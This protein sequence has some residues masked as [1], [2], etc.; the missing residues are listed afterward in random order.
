MIP[1]DKN[2]RHSEGNLFKKRI[3]REVFQD[4]LSQKKTPYN[5][6]WSTLSNCKYMFVQI[7]ITEERLG[8]QSLNA[9]FDMRYDNEIIRKD[10]QC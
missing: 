2:L 6:S 3:Y 7:G 4:Q 10:A 8:P 5:L 9:V 1:T